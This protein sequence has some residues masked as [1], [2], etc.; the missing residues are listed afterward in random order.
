MFTYRNAD[1]ASFVW[2]D[3]ENW[4]SEW[5]VRVIETALRLAELSL[6]HAD[7]DTAVWAAR[8]GLSASPVHTELTEALMRAHAARGE[9]KAVDQVFRSHV[10]ALEDLDIDEVAESTVDLHAEL[11]SEQKAS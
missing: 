2:V 8:K 6:A 4:V 7:P 10:A 9:K 11:R 3:V 5:D 1:R